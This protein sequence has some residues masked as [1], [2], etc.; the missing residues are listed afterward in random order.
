M[1]TLQPCSVPDIWGQCPVQGQCDHTGGVLPGPGGGAVPAGPRTWPPV[2]A[3]L[4]R[5]HNLWRWGHRGNQVTS[6]YC[7][8]V[9]VKVEAAPAPPPPVSPC[10]RMEAGARLGSSRR[11]GLVTAP[12]EWRGWGHTILYI[13]YSPMMCFVGCVAHGRLA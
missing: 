13:I 4:A 6:I 3:L 5:G 8:C 1:K 10:L 2:G 11:P 9:D 7:D 12:G